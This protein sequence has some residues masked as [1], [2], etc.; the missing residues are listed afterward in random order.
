MMNEIIQLRFAAFL[1]CPCLPQIALRIPC[2]CLGSVERIPSIIAC[3][4]DFTLGG[5]VGA[6]TLNPGIFHCF[7]LLPLRIHHERWPM[8]FRALGLP[9]A[10]KLRG[11]Q[12]TL[13]MLLCCAR[14]FAQPLLFCHP[15]RCSCHRALVDGNVIPEH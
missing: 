14:L 8:R 12:G 2:L 6:Q 4:V 7:P 11:D 10:R 1:F 9:I 3:P 15:C 5:L 13:G